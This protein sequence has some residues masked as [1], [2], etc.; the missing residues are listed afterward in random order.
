M[1]GEGMERL[2]A[3]KRD[4]D[5]NGVVGCR[6]ALGL[7]TAAL[8]VGVGTGKGEL[9]GSSGCAA[10]GASA[11]PRQE[12]PALQLGHQ[13]DQSEAVRF[14]DFPGARRL[15]IWMVRAR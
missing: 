1:V 13:A 5:G 3:P 2:R 6:S 14:L 7:I 9:F 15:G 12:A 11:G 4:R 10:I 8:D